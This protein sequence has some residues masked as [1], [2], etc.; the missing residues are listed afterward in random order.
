MY[1]WFFLPFLFPRCVDS[2]WLRVWKEAKN[3]RRKCP[4]PDSD[5]F[6]GVEFGENYANSSS[7]FAATPNR[8]FDFEK[9]SQLFVCAHNETLSVGAMCVNNKDCSPVRI[10]C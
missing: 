10:H 4:P 8:R 9:R 7:Q 1:S 6:N 2:V 3:Q 5:P